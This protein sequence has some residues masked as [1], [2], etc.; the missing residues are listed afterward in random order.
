MSPA[1][2][3]EGALGRRTSFGACGQRKAA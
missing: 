1:A 2:L 3:L